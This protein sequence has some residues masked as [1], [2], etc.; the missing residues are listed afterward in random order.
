MRSP[1]KAEPTKSDTNK[2]AHTSQSDIFYRKKLQ[3]TEDQNNIIDNIKGFVSYFVTH[4]LKIHLP[5]KHQW[6]IYKN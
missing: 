6:H 4:I 5:F 3:S 2:R 1:R